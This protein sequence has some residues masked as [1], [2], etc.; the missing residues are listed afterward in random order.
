LGST[1]TGGRATER[2]SPSLAELER[3]KVE[4]LEDIGAAAGD[5][6][7]GDQGMEGR[8]MKLVSV[9]IA[10]K[11]GDMKDEDDEL[12]FVAGAGET[13]GGGSATSFM[14]GVAGS[15]Y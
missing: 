9:W 4:E 5:P 7:L 1:G 13:S 2:T 11:V 14:R 12:A 6:I 10:A 3:L 8:G 15:I